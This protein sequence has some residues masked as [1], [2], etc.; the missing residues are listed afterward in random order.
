MR[1]SR[2]VLVLLAQGQR[3]PSHIVIAE[4]VKVGN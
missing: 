4:L 1:V 3:Q 2:L